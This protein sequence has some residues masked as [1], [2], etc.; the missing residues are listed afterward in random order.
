MDLLAE[1]VVVKN[2]RQTQPAIQ[3]YLGEREKKAL[4]ALIESRAWW[5]RL[6]VIQE[7]AVAS[8][9]PLIGCGTR[10]VQSALFSQFAVEINEFLD[11]QTT[12]EIM[13][14]IPMESMYHALHHRLIAQSLISSPLLILLDTARRVHV[15]RPH[16]VIY[17]ILG[18]ADDRY[19]STIP[20][21]YFLPL[22]QLFRKVSALYLHTSHDLD[23][24]YQAPTQ[25]SLPLPS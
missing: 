7:Y 24:L 2:P 21:D 14:G 9:E 12:N 15:T 3:R 19:A 20:T 23:L 16:D 22:D 10:W 13:R 25:K 17:A 18:L 11:R 5:S 4:F 6:W 8:A 1:V